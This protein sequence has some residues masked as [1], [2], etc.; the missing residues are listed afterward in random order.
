MSAICIIYIIRIMQMVYDIYIVQSFNRRV[1][2]G[3]TQPE[4]LYLG[5]Q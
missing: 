2:S 5:H 1:L 3:G 4:L